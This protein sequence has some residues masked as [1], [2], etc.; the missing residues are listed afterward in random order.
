MEAVY[1]NDALPVPLSCLRLSLFL[2]VFLSFPCRLLDGHAV[3]IDDTGS[4]LLNKLI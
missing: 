1:A 4:D 3:R 2:S